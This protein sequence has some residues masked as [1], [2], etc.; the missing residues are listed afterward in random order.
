MT[1]AAPTASARLWNAMP[2]WGIAADLL[3]PEVVAARR[4]RALRRWVVV[5]LALVVVLGV[6]G[7][8]FGLLQ[9]RHANSDL[10]SAQAATAQLIAQ[11]QK[12]AP[13]IHVQ[14]QV[15]QVRGEL[16]TLM[17]SDVD[18]D[19]MIRAIVGRMPAGASIAS[20]NMTVDG[21]ETSTSPGS[22]IGGGVLDT[23]GLAHV[24]GIA[25]TG[26]ARS[27]TDIAAYVNG[28]AAVPGVVA[29]YPT[30]EQAS[31][32]GSQFQIQVTLTDQVLSH[33]FDVSASQAPTGGH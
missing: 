28:L 14:D 8:V 4:V 12:Y 33:R 26:S 18:F 6:A 29:V 3:P 13:A 21:A 19:R 23:S 24:G 32:N 10:T 15:G 7:Y 1:L 2:G 11:Q 5:A 30:S 20:L 22:D 25:L 16:T 27:M 9:K 31:A 17:T